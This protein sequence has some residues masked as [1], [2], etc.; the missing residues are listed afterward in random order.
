MLFAGLTVRIYRMI[1]CFFGT[2]WGTLFFKLKFQRTIRGTSDLHWFFLSPVRT[3]TISRWSLLWN[4]FREYCNC[5]KTFEKT[6]SNILF[7]GIAV[8]IYH[9]KY[10]FLRTIWGTW[11]LKLKFQRTIRRLL[12]F[13][14]Y[15]YNLFGH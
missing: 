3:F 10:C 15:F 8:R 6:F 11:F 12:T 5:S 1:Y 9:M 2:I 13:I 7:A 4:K 14:D